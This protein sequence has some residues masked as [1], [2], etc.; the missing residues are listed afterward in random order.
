MKVFP[1]SRRGWLTI[2]HLVISVS[3][4]LINRF[5]DDPL[6]LRNGILLLAPLLELVALFPLS[7][8]YYL[9]TRDWAPKY[10]IPVLCVVVILNSYCWGFALSRA[11]NWFV[12]RN[13]SQSESN[14]NTND[15]SK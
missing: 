12:S 2:M 15:V 1:T 5:G 14:G 9:L 4:V 8:P 13:K 3:V 11:W 6:R 10:D 7:I